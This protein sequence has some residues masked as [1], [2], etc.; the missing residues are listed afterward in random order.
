MHRHVWELEGDKFRI[1]SASVRDAGGYEKTSVPLEEFRWS[2]FFRAKLPKPCGDADYK[3]L[4]KKAVML[5][6]SEAA[7]GLPGFLG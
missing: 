2:D 7:V 5:A 4:V 3:D 6:K 1:F